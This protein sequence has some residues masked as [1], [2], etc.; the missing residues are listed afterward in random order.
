MKFP[1]NLKD[2]Q[3]TC[4]LAHSLIWQIFRGPDHGLG[5]RQKAW[6]S[7]GERQNNG[8]GTVQHGQRYEQELEGETSQKQ[9][10]SMD[11]EG[12]TGVFWLEMAVGL[13]NAKRRRKTQGQERGV[14]SLGTKKRDRSRECRCGEGKEVWLERCVEAR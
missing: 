5:D 12:W 3:T 10:M 4:L 8:T 11:F 9:N 14:V 7:R 13:D 2:K 1:F 6:A